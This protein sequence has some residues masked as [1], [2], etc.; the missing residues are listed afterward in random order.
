[1]IRNML[2]DGIAL[3][4]RFSRIALV[5]TE[6]RLASGK[7]GADARLLVDRTVVANEFSKQVPHVLSAAITLSKQIE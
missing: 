2:C 5:E 6:G 4:H 3:F 1:M 7:F